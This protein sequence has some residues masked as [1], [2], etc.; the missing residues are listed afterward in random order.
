MVNVDAIAPDYLRCQW[1]SIG[2]KKKPLLRV[3][4]L[5]LVPTCTVLFKDKE[6]KRRFKV[7]GIKDIL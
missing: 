5:A 3:V 6:G 4:Y 7:N 1:L 2:P